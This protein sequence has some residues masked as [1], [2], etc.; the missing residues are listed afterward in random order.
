MSDWHPGSWRSCLVTQQPKW[1][2]VG[3]PF[4]YFE[5]RKPKGGEVFH[6][7][8]LN[9]EALLACQP[10]KN[11]NVLLYETIEPWDESSQLQVIMEMP[12]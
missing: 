4:T 12:K 2:G 9:P 7:C 3:E 1:T 6:A 5:W 11:A 8:W 10:E